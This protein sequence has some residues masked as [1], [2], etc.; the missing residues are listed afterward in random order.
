MGDKQ[1]VQN[2]QLIDDSETD[3]N[4]NPKTSQPG[5]AKA[6]ALG[7]S[8]VGKLSSSPSGQQVFSSA[9]APSA[10]QQARSAQAGGPAKGSGFTGV[11]RFLQA[12]VGSRLGEQV[13]GRVA[14]AGQQAQQRLGEAV[15]RFQTGLGKERGTFSAQEAAA[16]GALQQFSGSQQPVQAGQAVNFNPSQEEIAAYLAASSGRYAGPSG[17]EDIEGVRSQAGL[18]QT[19]AGQTQTT[20]GRTAL[21]QQLLGR[22]SQQYTRGQTALDALLLGQNS[23]QLAQSRRNAAG[24][25]KQLETQEKLAEEQARQTKEEFLGKGQEL[26]LER[27]AQLQNKLAAGK[28]QQESFTQEQADF[29]DKAKREIEEGVLSP[30]TAKRLFGSEEDVDLYGYTK[31][32]VKNLL[33]KSIPSLESSLTREQAASINALRQLKGEAPQYSQDT[34][35]KIIGTTSEITPLTSP[36]VKFDPQGVIK[37]KREDFEKQKKIL[38]DVIAWAYQT[39]KPGLGEQLRAASYSDFDTDLTKGTV[40]ASRGY[41]IR[42][43]LA[44]LPGYE[45]V[46]SD[47][48]GSAESGETGKKANEAIKAL[49]AIKALGVAGGDTLKV[50]K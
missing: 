24:L 23:A 17:L 4:G 13:A 34:L 7:S 38:D 16:R 47:L 27:A 22:G 15:G 11:G 6:G 43:P 37:Q 35:N 29:Y 39:G 14:Q 41:N 33:E 42:N 12:N 32:E 9:A 26:E 3:E 28:R 5:I 46:F 21:L 20:K 25:G 8:G 40:F 19:L 18:A 2:V 49:Q 30:E 44:A 31:N 48:F 10:P 50:R 36:G 45:K 1:N